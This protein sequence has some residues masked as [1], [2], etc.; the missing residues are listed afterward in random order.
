[1]V[2]TFIPARPFGFPYD[3][4]LDPAT[5]TLMVIDLQLDFLSPDGYFAQGLRSLP[6][7]RYS[8]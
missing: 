4:R 7:P 3:S 6:A 8:A 2:S 1:L 5:A